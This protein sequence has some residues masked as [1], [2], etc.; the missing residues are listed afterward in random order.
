MNHGLALWRLVMT[1][2]LA[3]TAANTA[4]GQAGVQIEYILVDGSRLWISGATNVR[5]F[6]CENG[7]LQGEASLQN[8]AYSEGVDAAEDAASFS[9]DVE[10]FACTPAPVRSRLVA[11]LSSDAGHDIH[12][13]LE[14]ASL[15]SEP[16]AH[17]GWHDV[18]VEGVLQMAGVARPLSVTVRIQRLTDE[19]YAVEG[20]TRLLLSDFGLKPPSALFGLVRAADEIEVE[21][22]LFAAISSGSGASAPPN[23]IPSGEMK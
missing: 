18:Y 12:F 1:L 15:L 3:G 19:R 23:L 13:E 22:A 4:L 9:A 10:A 17:L 21:F 11:A 16:P 7:K 2:A 8:A 5:S 14:R 6:R 20:E